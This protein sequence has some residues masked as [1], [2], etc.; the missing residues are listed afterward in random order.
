MP[1]RLTPTPD[2][3]AAGAEFV[4]RVGASTASVP[5]EPDTLATVVDVAVE[6]VSA[7][8]T[9]VVSTGVDG[10]EV[11]VAGV[12]AVDES[13]GAAGF[14]VTVDVEAE[15]EVVSVDETAVVLPDEVW[16]EDVVADDVDVSCWVS[17]EG[18]V[19]SLLPPPQALRVA[20]TARR[21]EAVRGPARSN[22]I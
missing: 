9:V 3:D 13:T 22:F 6:L 17:T 5:A 19:G 11:V 4:A 12:F 16:P 1:A 15:F 21:M 7:D 2:R 20:A 14:D 8:A 10:A 18:D